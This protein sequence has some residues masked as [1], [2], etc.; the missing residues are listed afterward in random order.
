MRKFGAAMTQWGR[1]VL[2]LALG[3]GSL[4]AAW[5]KLDVSMDIGWRE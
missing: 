1:A 5:Q 3:Q 2:W 4:V